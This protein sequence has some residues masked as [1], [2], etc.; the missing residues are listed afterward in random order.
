MSNFSSKTRARAWVVTVQVANME[1]AGLTQEEYENPEYLAEVFTNAWNDS[2]KNR[3][4]GIAV[5]VSANGLYHAH[6]AL[7]GNT[8]TLQNVSKIMFDSHTE[9]QLSGKKELTAYL[10]KTGKYAEK[11]EKVLYTKGLELIE[12]SQGARNDLDEIEKYLE[13]GMKPNEIMGMSLKYRRY[14][15]LIKSDFI[16]R[17]IQ[18]TPLIKDKL[19]V[20]WRVDESDSGR[21]YYYKQLCDQFG[22]ENV[23]LCNDF[24][25]GGMDYY[26]EQGAPDILF[27]NIV[28][29]DDISYATLLTILDKYSRGQTHCRYHNIYNIWK[30]VVIISAYPPEYIYS[31]IVEP[32]RQNIDSYNQLI[33]RLTTVVYHY[34]Q[35]GA[36]MTFSIPATEY[37]GYDDLIDRAKKADNQKE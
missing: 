21:I 18:D 17:R 10:N 20:E 7:Y 4:S 33:R 12:D 31:Q 23:Y 8:T 29:G 37:R 35:N 13:A 5:C 1:K 22:A 34:K 11:G 2:G 15:K 19:I 28:E 3:T 30:Y 9:P 36:Y 26:I 24:K 25:N 27:L 6:M 16:F 14:E 32:K